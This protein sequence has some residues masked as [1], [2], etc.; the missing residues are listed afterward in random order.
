MPGKEYEDISNIKITKNV[1]SIV[2]AS[3]IDPDKQSKD[4]GYMNSMDMSQN[5]VA[6]VYTDGVQV[7]VI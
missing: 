6:D 3:F 7:I 2:F 4:E 1:Y 5:E